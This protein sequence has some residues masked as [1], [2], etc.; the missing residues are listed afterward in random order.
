MSQGTPTKHAPRFQ[1][2]TGLQFGKLTVIGFAGLDKG[3]NSRWLCR[4]ECGGKCTHLAGNLKRGR[5]PSCGCLKKQKRVGQ[6]CEDHPDFHVFSG[7]LTRCF[8]PKDHTYKRYGGRGIRVCDRWREGGFWV[9]LSDMGPRPSPDHSIDRID[10]DGHYEP[11][12]CRW[13]TPKEQG[14]NRRTN[15]LITHDGLTLPMSEWAE[16]LGVKRQMI[17][18][19]LNKGWPVEKV[20]GPKLSNRDIP[21]KTREAIVSLRRNGVSLKGI[22]RAVGVSCSEVRRACKPIGLCA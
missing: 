16:R 18:D 10:N 14:R 11:G 20:L 22:A 9:F 2:L 5:C 1:D 21:D 15:R 7:M 17:Q 6:R 19:R 4:C 13:A 8:N 12:N 3:K